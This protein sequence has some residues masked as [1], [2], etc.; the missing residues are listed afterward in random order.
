MKVLIN[1]ADNKYKK[2]QKVNSWTGKYIAK[3][4]K[5]YSYGPSDIEE[6]FIKDN[7]RIFNEVRGNGLWLWK[8]Y[9]I[10]KTMKKC[11]EGD[12]IF[13]CDSGAFFIRKIDV[14]I[15]TMKKDECIWVSDIP[16]IESCFTKPICLQKMGC[17]KEEIKNSNQIQGTF[18]MA[19]CCKEA[20]EFV[21]KWLEYC[22]DYELISPEGCLDI[23]KNF[24]KEFVTHREDQSILSLLCKKNK[25]RV[26]R[27]PSQRGKYQAT[28]YNENYFFSKTIHEDKYKTIIFLHKAPKVTIF[29]CLRVIKNTI[30]N[31]IKYNLNL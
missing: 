2:T 13:Y 11:N 20:E 16:L 21:E 28:Y 1:Y 8:P 22:K 4:D 26:H 7:Q 6:D 10:L 14:L 24:E 12:I 27:D 3:F 19:K 9:F 31:T 29:S 23:D 15:E 17:D 18:F 5:V 30:F 25:I